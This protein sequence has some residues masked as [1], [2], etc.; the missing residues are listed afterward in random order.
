MALRPTGPADAG[1]TCL[2]TI[3]A[4]AIVAAP[5]VVQLRRDGFEGM[6]AQ[7]YD[8]VLYSRV[9]IRVDYFHDGFVRLG[10]SGTLL[11]LLPV[12]PQ[13]Q[14]FW[15]VAGS[16]VFLLVPL[17]LLV[18]RVVGASPALVSA[19][20]IATLLLSPQTFLAWSH[21]LVRTDVLVAGFI[22]SAMLF[23]AR[24]SWG[25][26]IAMIVTR[27]LVHETAFLF[28]AGVATAAMWLDTRDG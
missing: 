27:F 4:A 20:L 14:V 12:S 2:L 1:V 16:L 17:A 8:G 9:V 15:F 13:R 3:A 23:A 10:L 24:L 22:A 6:L 18:R 7:L 21:D 19:Y 25:L 28:G 26:A 5:H 11:A